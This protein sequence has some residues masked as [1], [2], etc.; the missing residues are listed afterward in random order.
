MKPERLP[1]TRPHTRIYDTVMELM[2][3]IGTGP[4]CVLVRLLHFRNRSTGLCNP[5]IR[6]LARKTGMNERT[7]RRHLNVLEEANLVR[8]RAAYAQEGDRSSNLYEFPDWVLGEGVRSPG[9]GIMPLPPS[10]NGTSCQEGGGIMPYKPRVLEPEKERTNEHM[11]HV[12]KEDKRTLA[13]EQC[14]HP[15][16]RMFP[17]GVAYC[18]KCLGYVGQDNTDEAMA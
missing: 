6:S 18:R 15:N 12:K 17:D 13:Q 5:S 11:G 14:P 1:R 8:R 4:W 2:A 9:T 7:I 3:E 16:I 10:K